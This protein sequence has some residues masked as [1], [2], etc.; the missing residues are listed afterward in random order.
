MKIKKT[1]STK[2]CILK[3]NFKFEGYRNCLETTRFEV[4]TNLS[5]NKKTSCG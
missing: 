5:E 3:Q 1:K 4:K 2:K